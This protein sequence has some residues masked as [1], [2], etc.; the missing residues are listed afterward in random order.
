MVVGKATGFE[1]TI[2]G[3]LFKIACQNN[4][5]V[6]KVSIPQNEKKITMVLSNIQV[7]D[8]GPSLLCN[9]D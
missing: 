9:T 7:S 2:T 3:D 1:I 5:F 6:F 4:D 8:Q